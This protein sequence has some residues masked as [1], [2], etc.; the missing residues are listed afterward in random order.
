MFSTFKNLE[1]LKK[2]ES[3]FADGTFSCSP[4]IFTQLYTIHSIINTSVV[5]LVYVLLPDKTEDTY[6]RM[7]IALNSIMPNLKPKLFMLDFEKGAMNAVINIYPDTKIKGCFF[8][9]SQSFWR[10]IQSL[11]FQKKYSEDPQFSLHLRELLALAYVPENK[12]IDYFESLL[13]TEFYQ[14]NQIYLTE[15]LDYFED[16]YIGRPNRRGH[17]RAAL[18]NINIWN[19]YELIKNDIPRTN[20]AIEGWHNGFKSMLNAVHPS[21]WTFIEALKKEDNLNQLKVEQEISGY[22]PPK[23]R[24]YKDSALR[25]KK[26]VLQFENNIS[27]EQYLRGIAANFQLQK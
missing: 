7:F 16:T 23:K 6:H 22:S 20:N 14:N 3:W 11:G 18:F 24:K 12:V 2:S 4:K 17:R 26:L 27:I 9:L 13:T 1:L 10:R 5:P 25:I 21:I 15:L 19:C 8:H